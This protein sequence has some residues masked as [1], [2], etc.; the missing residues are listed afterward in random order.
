MGR[1]ALAVAV[2]LTAAGCGAAAS[3]DATPPTRPQY[4]EAPDGFRRHTVREAGVSVALPIGFQVLAQR[5]A[6]Y[7]GTYINLTKLDPTF[8][9]PISALASPESPLKLFA[10][11]RVFWHERSTTAMLVQATYGRP[12]LTSL[13]MERMRRSLAGA[14]GRAGP[15]RTSVVALPSGSA[16][17][18]EYRTTARD[19]E[20]VYIVAG[21][22]GLWALMFRTPTPTARSRRT[23]F[24]VAA[25]T[26]ETSVPVGGLQRRNTPASP[27]A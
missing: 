17:R 3:R 1:L 20:I 15:L 22:T 10:F 27:G 16:L 24:D 8:R 23:Q 25:R 2:L 18:A 4:P 11:D 9:G 14:A 5:D 7:P 6:A 26:I 19:T 21:R 13:W 12:G